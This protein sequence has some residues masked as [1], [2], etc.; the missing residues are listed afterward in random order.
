MCVNLIKEN[1]MTKKLKDIQKSASTFVV[2][3][4]KLDTE[5]AFIREVNEDIYEQ[6]LLSF[7]KTY[8]L[9]IYAGLAFIIVGTAAYETSVY[10]RGRRTEREALRFEQVIDNLAFKRE[11][12]AVNGMKFLIENA[13]Y[14]YRDLAFVNLYSYYLSKN[15]MSD[16]IS[17]L[18]D[19]Q[20]NAYS[21]SYRHYA[22]MQYAYLKGD[23]LKSD[24]LE[25][26]LRPLI[27]NNQGFKYDAIYMLAVK[28]ID[29]NDLASAMKIVKGLDDKDA[30]QMPAFFRS[31]LAKVK[32]YLDANY[33]EK[34]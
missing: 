32:N 31:G 4:K 25:K 19:M 1:V 12:E 27:K 15:Q 8:R 3:G 18:M 11:T 14:G 22:V 16:A 20:K 6:S 26:L 2:G 17:V 29:M 30:A 9:F 13:H 5:G 24:E 10:F 21:R 34:K 28:Y 7:W 23:E 33:N